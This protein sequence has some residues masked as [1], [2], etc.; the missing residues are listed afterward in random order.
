MPANKQTIAG[1][2]RSYKKQRPFARNR[3]RPFHFT[4]TLASVRRA[5]QYPQHDLVVLRLVVIAER[6]V[7]RQAG[8]AGEAHGVVFVVSNGKAPP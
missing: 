7:R 2:A 4:Q 8:Y 5:V 3:E 6:R 1:M